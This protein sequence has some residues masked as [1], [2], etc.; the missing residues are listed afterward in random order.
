[1]DDSGHLELRNGWELVQLEH[2]PQ[3]ASFF[4]TILCLSNGYVGV[5]PTLDFESEYAIPGTFYAKLY[6]PALAV[7]TEMANA[8]SWLP[9]GFRLYGAEP[10]DWDHGELLQFERRLDMRRGLLHTEARVLQAGVGITRLQWTTLVHATRLHCGLVHGSITAE[11][12]DGPIGLES[13]IDGR[14][15]NSYMGGYHREIQTRHFNRMKSVYDSQNG[16]YLLSR[17]AGGH[18]DLHTA[19]HIA[20]DGET[21]RTALRRA[22][23][24]GERVETSV[25]RGRPVQFARFAA[26]THT[27]AGVP[28]CHSASELLRE[29]AEIG[30]AKLQQEHVAAWD[31]RWAT[32]EISMQGDTDTETATR[33]CVF[34]LQQAMHPSAE[35]YNIAARGLTSEYHSGHYFFNTEL[36]KLPYW[37]YTAPDRARALLSFRINTLD[38]AREHATGSELAGASY[39]EETDI[40]GQPASPWEIRVVFS[41]GHY[42]EWSG[43]ETMFVS[44]CVAKALDWYCSGQGDKQMLAE[45]ALEVLLETARFGYGLLVP[46]QAN[47]G[48]ANKSVMGGD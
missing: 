15:G 7:R 4:E 43:K 34:H 37:L 29:L 24:L 14:F 30:V 42:Y 10:F 20:V 9:L 3:H 36:F 33:F 35:T 6:D 26:F 45:Q 46:T 12:W 8:P 5:R 38:Q 16:L 47:T 21:A 11:D 41:G 25:I 39:P 27:T 19:S 22:H 40:G 44:A 28:P 23:C 1:M 17:L 18:C 2:V 32:A 13:W 48:V 31:H